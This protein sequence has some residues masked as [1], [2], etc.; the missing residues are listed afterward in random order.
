MNLDGYWAAYDRTLA[1]IRNEKPATFAQLKAILDTFEPPSSGEAFFPDGADDTL[2][3]ALDDAGWALH[4]VEGSYL[5]YAK[6]GLTRAQLT[7][8]E[9]DIYEGIR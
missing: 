5:Y 1:R 4:W 2:A 9:G 6:H 7:Y 3:A 8:V